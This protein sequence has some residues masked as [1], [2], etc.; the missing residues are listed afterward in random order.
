MEYARRI[1]FF[2]SQ[3]PRNVQ[4]NRGN[5]LSSSLPLSALNT[6]SLRRHPSPVLR[7]KKDRA[8]TTVEAQRF[9]H[10][11][12]RRFRR[13]KLRLADS[14]PAVFSL[15]RPP[16]PTPE[17]GDD[18]TEFGA[19][20]S[21]GI[22]CHCSS[23]DG[24]TARGCPRR[25]RHQLHQ[26]RSLLALGDGTGPQAPLTRRRPTVLLPQGHSQKNTRGLCRQLKTAKVTQVTNSRI[27]IGY[28]ERHW[29]ASTA[30]LHSSL[31]HDIGHV[32][33]THCPMH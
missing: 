32:V 26:W 4:K 30:E 7:R 9:P 16:I 3:D 5:L 29:V 27:S 11:H 21:V 20:G 13:K 24:P 23:T 18:C 25:L 22:C 10:C 31:A 17:V 14:A 15:L 1:V 28:D 6:L 33:R 8:A 19:S 12:C 2:V